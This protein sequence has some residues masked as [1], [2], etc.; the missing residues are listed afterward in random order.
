M[1][2]TKAKAG[3]YLMDIH[4]GK[5]IQEIL[6]SNDK[7]ERAVNDT[8]KLSRGFTSIGRSYFVIGALLGA[9]PGDIVGPVETARGHAIIELVSV[10]NYDSTDFEVQENVLEQDLLSTKQNQAFRDWLE[11][12]KTNADIVDNRK[13]YF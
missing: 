11:D 10:A 13:F 2:L 8:K 12:L 6:D 1:E 4:G 9:N 5:T 3:E 7:L